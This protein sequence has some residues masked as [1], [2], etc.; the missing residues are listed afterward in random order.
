MEG[1]YRSDS[2]SFIFIDRDTAHFTT[3]LGYLTRH[4]SKLG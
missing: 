4:L 3:I 2:D 1:N